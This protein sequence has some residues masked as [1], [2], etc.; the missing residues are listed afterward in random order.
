MF[1]TYANPDYQKYAREE[2]HPSDEE[3]SENASEAEDVAGD[4]DRDSQRSEGNDTSQEGED[5]HG[6]GDGEDNADSDN[7]PI[8]PARDDTSI[9]KPGGETHPR[10]ESRTETVSRVQST[11]EMASTTLPSV[12]S[13]NLVYSVLIRASGALV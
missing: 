8:V 9:P 2:I 1:W 4:Q 5:E 12:Y 11:V 6:S 10:V 3:H 13:T 7:Y